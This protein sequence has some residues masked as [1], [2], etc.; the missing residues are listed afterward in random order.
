MKITDYNFDKMDLVVATA[1]NSYL[2]NLTPEAR[3]ETLTGIVR[4]EGMKT[5]IEGAALADLIESAKAAAMITSE[6]WQTG[7]GDYQRALDCIRETLPGV[8]GKKYLAGEP[9]EFLRFIEDW[10]KQ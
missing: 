8:D 5:V 1:V 3:E 7:E 2:K 9:K 10:A 6:D 4:Q